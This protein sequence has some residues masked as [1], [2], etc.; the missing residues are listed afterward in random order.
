MV[1]PLSVVCRLLEEVIGTFPGRLERFVQI[2]GAYP[3]ASRRAVRTPTIWARSIVR[4]RG[5][6]VASRV[7]R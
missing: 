1:G 7:W 3:S 6:R 5:G 4:R 2:F